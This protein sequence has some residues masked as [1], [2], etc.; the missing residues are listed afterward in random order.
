[1]AFRGA[2]AA[3]RPSD[4][5]ALDRLRAMRL[6]WLFVVGIWPPLYVMVYLW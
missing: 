2:P 3:A 4:D 5:S 6:Y 1:M